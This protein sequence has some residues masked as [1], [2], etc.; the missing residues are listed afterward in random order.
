MK[1]VWIISLPVVFLLAAAAAGWILFQGEEE[2]QGEEIQMM[3][4]E[5]YQGTVGGIREDGDAFLVLLTTA[6]G[7]Y[8][9]RVDRTDGTI[10]SMQLNE[11]FETE[12]E[13][14][15]EEPEVLPEEEIRGVVAAALSESAEI[16]ALELQQ[17]E[18]R[19]FYTVTA[20]DG[21]QESQLEIDAVT[22]E[23]DLLTT[24]ETAPPEPLTEEEAGAIALEEFPGTI[25]DIDRG[26]EDGRLVYEIEIESGDRDADI[27]IDAYT[28]EVLRVE[29]DE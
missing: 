6:E 27:W 12:P 11:A 29:I 13:A 18:N 23:V 8:D 19:S 15:D 1:R 10:L 17:A 22:G 14:P 28:G 4:E 26:E 25:D 9:V 16:I 5:R 21:T 20:V 3:L 24:Q 2:V 7:E